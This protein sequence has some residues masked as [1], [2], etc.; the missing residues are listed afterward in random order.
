MTTRNVSQLLNVIAPCSVTEFKDAALEYL[1]LQLESV[2]ENH[3]IDDLDED[4]LLELDEV[5]RG[6]QLNCLPFAKS[7]RSET[8]LH[9][10]HP[11]LAGDIDE[12]RQRRLR[13]MTFRATL[14][15]DDTRLSSSFKARIGSLDDPISN[16]PNQDKPRGKTKAT[17]NAPFSPSIR[18]KDSSADLMFDMD[19]EDSLTPESTSSLELRTSA[20]QTPPTQWHDVVITGKGFANSSAEASKSRDAA[21]SPSSNNKTWSSPAMPSAKLDLREIISAQASSSR[22]SQLSL[23]LSAQNS[24][25]ESSGRSSSMQK[26]LS[27]K[28]RKKIQQ[29]ALQKSLNQPRIQVETADVKSS[30]WQVPATGPKTSLKDVLGDSQPSPLALSPHPHIPRRSASPDTRFAGQQRSS[31]NP[32]NDSQ[33]ISNPSHRPKHKSLT[34]VLLISLGALCSF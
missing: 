32:S 20:P 12:E 22:V 30:P 9:E 16:S 33:S 31:W 21:S 2:L 14:Y 27:Q 19:D 10:R 28:E 7:G 6:N 18:P 11:N 17:R 29:Q 23:S 15:S 24:R 4:L 13:D 5:V 1:C 26:P 25:D 34:A 3:M 8:L